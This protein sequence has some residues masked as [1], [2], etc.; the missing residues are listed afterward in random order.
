MNSPLV[1][2]EL[3]ALVKELNEFRPRSATSYLTP[4][5]FVQ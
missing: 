3:R 2:L 4:A 5:E 1:F